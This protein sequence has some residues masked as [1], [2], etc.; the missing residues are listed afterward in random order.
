ME[1]ER[2]IIRRWTLDD[3]ESLFDYAKDPE[4]GP[5]A[6]WP[7]HKTIEDSLRTIKNVFN[8]KE[9]YALALKES[10]EAIGAIELKLRGN[11]KLTD[12]DDECEL[13]Y[14]LGKKF[15]GRGLMPEAAR[16]ILR[17]AFCDLGMTKVWCGYYTGNEKSKRVQE[18]C[19]FIPQKVIR[20]EYLPLMDEKRDVNV[21]LL[22]REEFLKK[23][24]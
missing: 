24:G 3:A 16:E 13:G 2:L 21:N 1:T 14:W 15:W 5:V 7:A 4:V 6:G 11:T 19:D 10:N 9:A 17:H 20:D 18:K 23:E 12:K 22:T 8:G